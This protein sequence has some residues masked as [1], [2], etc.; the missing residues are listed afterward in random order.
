MIPVA[1]VIAI[2][3]SPAIATSLSTMTSKTPTSLMMQKK[4]I[5]KINKI[6]LL[7]TVFMPVPISSLRSAMLVPII[8]A[9]KVGTRIS[10]TIGLILP[11]SSN[12]MIARTNKNPT[13]DNITFL[14]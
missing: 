8:S 6:E 2:T 7:E 10:T 5:E 9:A 14:L 3:F 4:I 1:T 11:L 12:T 13:S